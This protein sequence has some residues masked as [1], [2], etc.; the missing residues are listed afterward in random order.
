MSK[1]VLPWFPYWFWIKPLSIKRHYKF[2]DNRPV[3]RCPL[4]PSIAQLFLT[5]SLCHREACLSITALGEQRFGRKWR[6]NQFSVQEAWKAGTAKKIRELRGRINALL[7]TVI[8]L[9]IFHI[10]SETAW[11]R[12]QPLIRHLSMFSTD[13]T[14]IYSRKSLLISIWHMPIV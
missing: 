2:F 13:D 4:Q 7:V 8:Y 5:G 14:P 3:F 10:E 9:S 1:P 6:D 12:L 11:S